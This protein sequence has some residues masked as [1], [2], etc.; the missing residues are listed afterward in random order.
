VPKKKTKKKIF[1]FWF[2]FCAVMSK[3]V[4][5]LP[6]VE[7]YRP[8]TLDDIIGNQKVVA[9]LK[10]L[11]ADGA[12][13][14]LIVSG[15]PGCGKTT[16]LLCMAH[17]LLGYDLPPKNSPKDSDVAA[18][19]TTTIDE[20]SIFLAR[21][22]AEEMRFYSNN[23][24]E[25]NASD[26]NGVGI[27]RNVIKQF[28]SKETTFNEKHNGRHKLVILDEADNLTK[29]AQESLR[30]LIETHEST[31]RFMLACND[32][33]RLSEAL[34]SRCTVLRFAKLP[35]TQIAERLRAIA[36]AEGIVDFDDDGINSL[37]F[38]ADGDMRNAIN[39]LHTVF[40]AFGSVQ[41]S[42]VNAVFDTPRPQL[43]GAIIE[44]C[45]GV[46]YDEALQQLAELLAHGYSSLDILSLMY[47]VAR[48]MPTQSVAA[49][50]TAAQRA[51]S[52]GETVKPIRDDEMSEQR[53]LLLLA[54]IGQCQMRALN[55][56]FGALQMQALVSAMCKT[57]AI[58]KNEDQ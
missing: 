5:P 52:S 37:V 14:H 19:T 56:C 22:E 47:R 7:K 33:T 11:V 18:T 51:A 3:S 55:G 24:L 35:E 1:L 39:D 28:A 48:A 29:D 9:C 38:R 44:C 45:L 8:K 49:R 10:A 21:H 27:V 34:Q 30:R 43:I 40:A 23:V 26:E 20:R 46:R 53:K 6:W 41:F 15:P 17:Q 57:C 25:I 50:I 58:N 4:K 32:S 42:H 54:D 12:L 16:A 31:T 36:A 13:P 2:V